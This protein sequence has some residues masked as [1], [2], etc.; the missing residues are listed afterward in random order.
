MCASELIFCCVLV[1]NLFSIFRVAELIAKKGKPEFVKP[2]VD[3]AAADE[4]DKQC[5]GFF[6]RK[7]RPITCHYCR[8]ERKYH[9]TE[10]E[11][12]DSENFSVDDID[13]QSKLLMDSDVVLHS[14]VE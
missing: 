3:D 4:D 13:C 12:E 7:F 1:N 9:T 5:P 11:P 14:V 2:L 8:H 10:R 6:P